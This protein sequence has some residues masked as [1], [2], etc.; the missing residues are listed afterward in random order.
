MKRFCGNH[1]HTRR[2][3]SQ[4]ELH[5]LHPLDPRW[6]I[7]FILPWFEFLEMS[8]GIG[9]NSSSLAFCPH[10]MRRAE[11]AVEGEGVKQDAGGEKS[12]QP[13]K[14][15]KQMEQSQSLLAMHLRWTLVLPQ[16]SRGSEAVVECAQIQSVWSVWSRKVL[17]FT[18]TSRAIT[19]IT[20]EA[21][22]GV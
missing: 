18:T 19:P 11:S 3:R 4:D 14:G 16:M 17:W 20:H 22:R 12:T 8:T 21:G 2:Q 5:R 13:K 10:D 15:G 9:S 6:L 1:I 7:Q